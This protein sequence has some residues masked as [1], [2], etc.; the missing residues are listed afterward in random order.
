MEPQNFLK[1]QSNFEKEKQ[2]WRHHNSELQVILQSCNDQ[3]SMVLAQKNR[4]IGHW[5]IINSPGVNPLIWSI[6]L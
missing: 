1:S 4:H 3:N 5:N 2:G 6:K